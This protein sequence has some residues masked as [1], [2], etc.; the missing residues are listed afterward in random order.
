VDEEIE[1]EELNNSEEANQ[2]KMYQAKVRKKRQISFSKFPRSTPHIHESFRNKALQV[3]G[4]ENPPLQN[5]FKPRFPKP[6]PPRSS[7][8]P[9]DSTKNWNSKSQANPRRRNLTKTNKNQKNVHNKREA[10][11][12]NNRKCLVFKTLWNS[13]PSLHLS[14]QKTSYPRD[15]STS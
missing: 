4:N 3:N 6:K 5:G 7:R 10:C 2:V 9:K 1:Y 15:L 12:W 14:I 13:N 8:N 11:P